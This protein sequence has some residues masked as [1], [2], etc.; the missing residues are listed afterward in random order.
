MKRNI[1]ETQNRNRL[2]AT[3]LILFSLYEFFPPQT[4]DII[5]NQYTNVHF[6]ESLPYEKQ[7]FVSCHKDVHRVPLRVLDYLFIRS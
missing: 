3:I 1:I 7:H 2:T 4:L 6:R 5:Q